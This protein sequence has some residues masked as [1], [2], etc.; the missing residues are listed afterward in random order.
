MGALPKPIAE[1]VPPTGTANSLNDIA[2]TVGGLPGQLAAVIASSTEG[3]AAAVPATAKR[4]ASLT[5]KTTPVSPLAAR[6]TAVAGR[7][8]CSPLRQRR[9]AFP[10]VPRSGGFVT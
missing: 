10:A 7:P 5:G 4:V 2:R 3:C 8:P 6:R 1:V 9:P